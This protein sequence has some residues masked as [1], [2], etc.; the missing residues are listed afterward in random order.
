[1]RY[2]LKTWHPTAG[3]KTRVFQLQ[4]RAYEAYD[5]ALA[6]NQYVMKFESESGA[7]YRDRPQVVEITE[8]M[9]G[10]NA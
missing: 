8:D 2:I 7:D 5:L 10:R 3:Q 4:G 9:R 6:N 1:M